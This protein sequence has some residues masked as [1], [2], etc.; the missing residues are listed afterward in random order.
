MRRRT[1]FER[2]VGASKKIISRN[3][4]A[5]IE[6]L[7]ELEKQLPN[8]DFMKKI[9]IKRVLARDLQKKRRD[10]LELFTDYSFSVDKKLKRKGRRYK[11]LDKDL[12]SDV[13]K[14]FLRRKG[15][16]KQGKDY[17]RVRR[18]T[19]T[20]RIEPK[21][22]LYVLEHDLLGPLGVLRFDPERKTIIDIGVNVPLVK[23]I[24]RELSS[25]EGRDVKLHVGTILKLR[26]LNKHSVVHGFLSPSGDKLNRWMRDKL[27]V[28]IR[29]LPSGVGMKNY[30]FI[31]PKAYKRGPTNERN[32]K[33]ANN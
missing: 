6:K 15:E 30:I 21:E 33:K 3:T 19:F 2:L 24:E 1:H 7:V 13:I 16:V 4:G 11:A 9:R 20:E 32:E 17:T 14:N 29:F 27:G 22:E 31:S 10:L 28:N 8:D 26:L 18:Y 5:K 23:M 25:D 12:L